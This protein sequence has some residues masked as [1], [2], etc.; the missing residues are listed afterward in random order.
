MKIK[1]TLTQKFTK[2]LN[3]LIA[4]RKLLID[5]YED[6]KAELSKDP[7]SGDL[8]IGTSG[9]RKIRLKS[10]SSGKSGGFRICYYYLIKQSE[11]FLIL[12]Y[13]KNQQDNITAE[14][15]KLLKEIANEIKKA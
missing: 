15:K 11:I 5:D 12:I 3:K 4:S 10:V 14:Q 1:I 6:L 2:E 7:Y 13:S 8:I 9:I